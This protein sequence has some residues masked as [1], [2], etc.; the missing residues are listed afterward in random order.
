MKYL[1][2][3]ADKSRVILDQIASRELMIYVSLQLLAAHANGNYS[4]FFTYACM[5]S[6]I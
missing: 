1:R 4:L 2:L 5:N 6:R 3:N